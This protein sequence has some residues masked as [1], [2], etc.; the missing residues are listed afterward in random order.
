MIAWLDFLETCAQ[1]WKIFQKST[2]A[3][4]IKPEIWWKVSKNVENHFWRPGKWKSQFFDFMKTFKNDFFKNLFLQKFFPS[5]SEQVSKILYMVKIISPASRNDFQHFLTLFTKFQVLFFRHRS[6]FGRFFKFVHRFPKN[7]AKQ[8]SWNFCQ[9][10]EL[11]SS[12]ANKLFRSIRCVLK[13]FFW[14]RKK[15]HFNFVFVF[16]LKNH[17]TY[18]Q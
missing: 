8:S 9:M 7:L 3:W 15:K 6:I 1:I 18:S 13:K 17:E 16:T 2:S 11:P 5:N 4:K 14:W 12:M 10:L